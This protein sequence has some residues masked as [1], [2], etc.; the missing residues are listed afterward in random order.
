MAKRVHHLPRGHRRTVVSALNVPGEIVDLGGFVIAQNRQDIVA[1]GPTTVELIAHEDIER[2]VGD[3]P[4]L[5]HVL[6]SLTSRDTTISRQW[7]VA[8]A[9]L[10]GAAHVGHLLCE[11]NLRLSA[12]GEARDNR[13]HLPVKQRDLGDVLGY[14]P[15]HINRA[16]RQL[17]EAGFVE[18]R[19]PH[20]RLLDPEGLARFARFDPAYLRVTAVAAGAMAA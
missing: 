3:D 1:C 11:L 4:R 14:S 17:R 15:V 7:Q 19:G 16:V 8:A 13:F 20:V 2:L 18:W 12:A 6:M 10:N 5:A 9:T